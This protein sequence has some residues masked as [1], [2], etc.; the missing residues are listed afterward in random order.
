MDTEKDYTPLLTSD[1][2]GEILD[3]T[4]EVNG[5]RTQYFHCSMP[6]PMS[7]FA[8]IIGKFY[9]ERELQAPNHLLVKVEQEASDTVPQIN[10]SG[11]PKYP[12]RIANPKKS[13]ES[14]IPCR[15][16]S[17]D[18]ST[19]PPDLTPFTNLVFS[20]LVESF[21]N[22]GPHPFSRLDI[23]IVPKS[24]PHEGL[25]SPSM[26]FLAPCNF[27]G[28]EPLYVSRL[29]HEITH[30]WWGLLIGSLDW[31]EEWLSEGFATFSEDILYP[32][33]FH[34]HFPQKPQM[35]IERDQ[36]L[37]ILMRFTSLQHELQNTAGES[38]LHQL[39]PAATSNATA[40]N[41][42]VPLKQFMHCHYYKGYLLLW[43][44]S[45]LVGQHNFLRFLK[46]YI[47]QYHGQ[48]V[49]S[50]IFLH[51]YHSHFSSSHPNI[52]NIADIKREWLQASQ[53]PAVFQ[54]LN[55]HSTPLPTTANIPPLFTSSLP[56]LQLINTIYTNLLHNWA[57]F[58]PSRVHAQLHQL[59][60]TQLLMLLD[61]I[62]NDENPSRETSLKQIYFSH[63]VT[64][65]TFQNTHNLNATLAHRFLELVVKFQDKSRLGQVEA[66]L[67][68]NIAMGVYLYGELMITERY[69]FQKCGRKVY[70]ELINIYDL[71]TKKILKE[72]LF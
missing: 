15:L 64:S 35:E 72:M 62:L 45:N 7:T 32:T 11:H 4:P 51:F 27:Y 59:S 16:F 42:L 65:S 71:N 52:I 1:Q 10:C 9:L 33:A 50:D 38:G 30:S 18:P 12:C 31:T 22:F 6:L 47:L 43:H 44:L 69:G 28:N 36:H 2:P 41:G 23:V 40:V 37:Q 63:L 39:T 58:S 5:R 21:K 54:N 60:T 49:T 20:S 66:F 68:N 14:I 19:Q 48:L 67:K 56:P 46:R 25:S 13:E 17:L 3:I 57:T 53:L 29:P 70:N 8:I 55:F 34:A 24:Y 61:L 26:I